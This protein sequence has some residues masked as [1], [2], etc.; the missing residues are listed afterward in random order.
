MA[1]WYVSGAKNRNESYFSLSFQ[2]VHSIH[3]EKHDPKG[4]R[5]AF[6]NL[7][8]PL[9]PEEWL[10]LILVRFLLARFDNILLQVVFS[11]LE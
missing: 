3:A 5:V 1:E 2:V 9:R 6:D 7:V 11:L 4:L 10:G 8:S